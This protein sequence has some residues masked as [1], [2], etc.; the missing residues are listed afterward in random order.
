MEDVCHSLKVKQIHWSYTIHING[1][2][3]GD[4]KYLIRQGDTESLDVRG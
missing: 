1:N 4:T 2:I 3:Q